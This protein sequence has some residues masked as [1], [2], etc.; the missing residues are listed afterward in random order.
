MPW[1]DQSEELGSRKELINSWTLQNRRQPESSFES[2][3]FGH[4]CRWW[5]SS[6]VR[7]TYQHRWIGKKT[8]P[9]M[10]SASIVLQSKIQFMILIYNG[11]SVYA[12]R[13]SSSTSGA[14][15]INLFC[16]SSL[17]THSAD[18]QA[19]VKRKNIEATGTSCSNSAIVPNLYELLVPP[20]STADFS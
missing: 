16:S 19:V 1:F 9:K 12:G 17:I 20:I 11:S 8:G 10:R 14:S 6:A 4:L 15:A 3:N 7:L 5:P 2:C 13:A 18:P